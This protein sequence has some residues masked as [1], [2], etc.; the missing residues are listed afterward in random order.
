MPMSSKVRKSHRVS[1]AH[2][3]EDWGQGSML[4]PVAMRVH[5]AKVKRAFRRK[6]GRPAA[7][8]VRSY[9]TR[10]SVAGLALRGKG[11]A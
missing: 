9:F 1:H 5:K 6:C 3:L 8:K 4:F 7:D 10:A 11:R 2:V